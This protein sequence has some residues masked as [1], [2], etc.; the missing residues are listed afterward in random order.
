MMQGTRLDLRPCWGAYTYRLPQTPRWILG[1]EG[2]K[3]ER[4]GENEKE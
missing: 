3:Q 2:R 1:L 4:C